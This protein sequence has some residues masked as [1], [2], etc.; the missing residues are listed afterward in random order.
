MPR[1]DQK[2]ITVKK[3]VY[4]KA[5]EDAKELG[6]KSTASYVSELILKKCKVHKPKEA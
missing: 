3:E 5:E 6:K 2:T 1:A 4:E